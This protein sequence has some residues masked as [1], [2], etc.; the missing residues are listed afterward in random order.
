MDDSRIETGVSC[1]VDRYSDSSKERIGSRSAVNRGHAIVIRGLR[2]DSR[3]QTFVSIN[4]TQC[5]KPSLNAD[6]LRQGF[7]HSRC[8]PA[9]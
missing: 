9:V 5:P 1:N 7:V 8:D 6:A 2:Q 4:P 3:Q